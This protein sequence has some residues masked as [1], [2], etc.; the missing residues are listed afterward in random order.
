MTGTFWALVPA[1]VAIALALISK[2]VYS[3]LFV[4]IVIGGIFYA[5]DAGSGF[6]GF[7]THV[8][9]D[10]FA[11][12]LADA[13]N[14]GILVFLVILGIMVA[15]M[16]KAGG[17][18]AFGRWAKKHIKSKVGAQVATIIL[19]ICI[20]IDD[21]FNC[22]TVGSV[23]KPVTDK[24]G[25]S[26]EKLAYLIDSTA[27]PV[28]II[29][30][31]SSWAAAVAGFVTE[32]EN[33]IG[34]FCKAIPFNFYALLTL[35]MMFAMVFMKF[36]YGQMSK[37]EKALEIMGEETTEEEA[38]GNAKGKVIDLLLPV[39]VLIIFCVIGLIYS[40]GFF[41]GESESHLNFIDAFS[42]AD[43]SVGLLYGSFGA[44]VIAIIFYLCRRVLSFKD[45]AACIPEGFKAM[46]PAILILTLAWTLKGMTDS[47]GAKDY[48]AGLVEGSAAGLKMFLPAIIF[49]IACF[50]AFA[51]GTSWGTFGILIPIC[52]AAFPEGAIRIVSISAC[53][54]GAVCGDHCSPISD[55]TIM[56]SAGAQCNH[57]NHVSTQL[58]YAITCAAVS[59]VAY[60]VAGLTLS[61]G[62][63]AS[64]IISWIVGL[65]VMLG[66]LIFIK[67]K[68]KKA[69]PAEA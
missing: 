48:V 36:E 4:G 30:P 9:T 34:L 65:A 25:V 11:G 45:T 61:L 49:V 16:N 42:N 26:K 1:I 43:A 56:A 7:M 17:S 19:G 35:V 5:I 38:V 68:Q 14:V 53:M 64:G 18:A 29:A 37:Y 22:L 21:Y 32:G 39:I 67:N 10:G 13:Y 50:L 62:I 6:T 54:A 51:T 44:L 33:G 58:P 66:V 8:F 59:F 60:L 3:S 47:L 46:V 57:V 41:D 31:V 2:E 24:Y 12:S 40:G 23:M 55:T 27:A 15:L 69:A 28:C 52:I 20:F 63:V